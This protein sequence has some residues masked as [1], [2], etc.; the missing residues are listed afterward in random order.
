MT[1][2]FQVGDQGR[3]LRTY[4]AALGDVQRQ[5]SLV[6]FL[7]THT[8]VFGK[9]MLFDGQRCFVDVHL[10][11]DLEQIAIAPQ[12][13]TATGT[14]LQRMVFEVRNLLLWKQLAFVFGM[15]RLAANLAAIASG[16]TRR[17][18]LDNVRRGRLGGGRRVFF[19]RGQLLLEDAHLN[20]Q[21]FNLPC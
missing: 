8:P 1:G 7:T 12:P 6:T 17:L 13:A 15:A 20:L 5:R 4:Q 14:G 2:A 10:L 19:G 9:V 11:H 18:R 21:S 3:Q 16:A